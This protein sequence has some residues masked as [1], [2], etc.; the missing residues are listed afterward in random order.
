MAPAVEQGAGVGLRGA[1]EMRGRAT[2][3]QGPSASW[4]GFPGPA[5]PSTPLLGREQ[6]SHV[7][8]SGVALT[9]RPPR[10]A[11]CGDGL[12]SHSAGPEPGPGVRAGITFLK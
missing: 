9:P 3:L 8:E 10:A 4:E 11:V 12:L 6:G 1:C 7:R 5:R 2:S